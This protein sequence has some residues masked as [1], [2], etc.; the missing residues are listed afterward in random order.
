MQAG[1]PCVATECPGGPADL[2]ESGKDGILVAVDDVHALA[3]ALR[4]L[5]LD[6]RARRRLGTAASEKAKLFAPERVYPLW[7]TVIN[8]SVG[9]SA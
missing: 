6:D 1:V 9:A 4:G 7:E 2:I 8:D 3:K 5:A